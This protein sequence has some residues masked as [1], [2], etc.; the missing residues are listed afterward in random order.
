M[1][2][3]MASSVWAPPIGTPLGWRSGNDSCPVCKL[4]FAPESPPSAPPF[5]LETLCSALGPHRGGAMQAL[6]GAAPSTV[7]GP[8]SSTVLG[9]Q[10]QADA[11][12]GPALG[13]YVGA[14]ASPSVAAA[15]GK[16][17][18][19]EANVPPPAQAPP[20]E[21]QPPLALGGPLVKAPPPPTTTKALLPLAQPVEQVHGP[22]VAIPQQPLA[23]P[24]QPM[25]PAKPVLGLR[26]PMPN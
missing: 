6:A 9:P 22:R 17:A 5:S 13:S 16:Q 1:T 20:T 8:H 18:E 26:V 15:Q 14:A 23:Q 7:Q 2:V 12:Q 25:P 19:E 11:V 21:P 3:S 10:P 24:A 4:S